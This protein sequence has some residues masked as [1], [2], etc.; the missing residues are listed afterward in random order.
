MYIICD[1]SNVI[2]DMATDQGSLSRGLPYLDQGGIQYGPEE[3]EG[4]SWQ[5]RQWVG[6]HFDGETHTPDSPMRAERAAWEAE[7]QNLRQVLNALLG[8][9]AALEADVG[10]LTLANVEAWP[11]AIAHVAAASSPAEFIARW[12][13]YEKKR[14]LF[15]LRF[16]RFVMT[17]LAGAD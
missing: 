7:T 9:E 8:T 17:R 10:E 11:E 1:A 15:T 12:Q 2:Q 4:I 14:T 3:L 5:G 13:T 16:L 6:D